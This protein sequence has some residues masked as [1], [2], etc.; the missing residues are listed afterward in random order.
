MPKVGVKQDQK[1]RAAA[2]SRKRKAPKAEPPAATTKKSRKKARAKPAPK[3]PLAEYL[4][5]PSEKKKAKLMSLAQAGK[6][7]VADIQAAIATEMAKI[8]K[9]ED[10]EAERINAVR[11][12]YVLRHRLLKD[13]QAVVLKAL[14]ANKADFSN[15][16]IWQVS[17]VIRGS[18]A[19]PGD[20]VKT[21]APPE[22]E[23]PK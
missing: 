12:L 23:W 14:E 13:L 15:A 4:A 6:I 10:A 1:R 20:Q 5:D 17:V 9:L 18:G 16:A 22:S 7:G 19:G 11:P 21:V 2:Q 8:V 3:S